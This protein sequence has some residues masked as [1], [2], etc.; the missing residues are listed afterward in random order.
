MLWTSSPWT[1][2]G[3]WVTVPGFADG[4]V[5]VETAYNAT[6]ITIDRPPP[7][8]LDPQYPWTI[9]SFDLVYEDDNEDEWT[10][11]ISAPTFIPQDSNPPHVSRQFSTPVFPAPGRFHRGRQRMP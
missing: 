3:S 7:S 9:S 10:L 4:E 6:T 8:L 1:T 11:V 2:L 5:S